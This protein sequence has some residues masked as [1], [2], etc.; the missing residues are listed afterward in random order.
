M[1][2]GPI[3]GVFASQECF[4]RNEEWWVYQLCPGKWVRQ[5]HL[6]DKLVQ[7]CG[8]RLLGVVHRVLGVLHRVLGVLHRVPGAPHRV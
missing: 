3:E 6:E 7:V 1:D 2:T 4:Y 8:G 5:Y